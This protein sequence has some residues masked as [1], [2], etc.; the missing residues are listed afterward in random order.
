MSIGQSQMSAILMIGRIRRRGL[1]DTV[2]TKGE[3]TMILTAILLGL[4]LGTGLLG[5]VALLALLESAFGL[6][7]RRRSGT[8]STAAVHA[9]SSSSDRTVTRAARASNLSV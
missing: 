3:N 7:Q 2:T 4:F 9:A 6:G 5:V 8:A 1:S